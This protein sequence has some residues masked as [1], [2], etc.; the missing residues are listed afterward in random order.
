MKKI[1]DILKLL[2]QGYY[3]YSFQHQGCFYGSAL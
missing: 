2:C 3:D 1:T